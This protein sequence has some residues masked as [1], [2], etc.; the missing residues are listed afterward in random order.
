MKSTA[1][2]YFNEND[3]Y[4]EKRQIEHICLE[5][6]LVSVYNE[7]GDFSP[8]KADRLIEQAIKD[9]NNK[10]IFVAKEDLVEELS[11]LIP[12][13]YGQFFEDIQVIEENFIRFK[14]ND[15]AAPAQQQPT[16]VNNNQQQTQQRSQQTQ[17]KSAGDKIVF[18][19]NA[20]APS[21]KA[22][23]QFVKDCQ[24]FEAQIKTGVLNN[25]KLNGTPSMEKWFC[26]VDN[27]GLCAS[28]IHTLYK[29]HPIEAVKAA[30]ENS[31]I[32]KEGFDANVNALIGMVESSDTVKNGFKYIFIV[33]KDLNIQSPNQN[34]VSI[35]PLQYNYENPNNSKILNH[36]MEL[37]K[38]IES[39]DVN[40]SKRSN[41]PSDEKEYA[42]EFQKNEA[43]I[44]YIYTYVKAFTW[45][46]KNKDKR[47]K[48]STA[49]SEFNKALKDFLF[50][51]FKNAYQSLE[52]GTYGKGTAFL[53]RS[54]KNMYTGLKKDLKKE[55]DDEDKNENKKH[56]DEKA[57]KKIFEYANYNELCK[58]LDLQA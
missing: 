11:R 47:I 4:D 51:D 52:N 53:A 37:S 54:F 35:L 48:T 30:Y 1:V 2:C 41:L 10:L 46:T 8:E 42:K 26:N 32:S 20:A 5:E 14:E 17:N 43:N 23:N 49:E 28:S 38:A 55:R 39:K 36:I 58:L 22:L 34:I 31:N 18:I 33:P 12:Q 45:W 7:D 15:Q 6:D 56:E 13:E 50:A 19:C 9:N 3:N 29:N 21:I 57:N 27:A 25:I 40:L 16:T 44:K 24:T